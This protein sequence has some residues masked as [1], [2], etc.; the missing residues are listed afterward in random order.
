MKKRIA[1]LSFLIPAGMMA[2]SLL[3]LWGC[4]TLNFG[5]LT[6]PMEGFIPIFFGAFFFLGSLALMIASILRP[7]EKAPSLAKGEARKVMVLVGFLLAF[8][9]I[10]PIFGFSLSTLGLVFASSQVMDNRIRTSFLL[11]GGV[12]AVCYLIFILWLKIPLPS[13]SL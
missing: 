11:A 2:V 5:S 6:L 1:S 7:E 3:Y 10:L 9:L 8:V 4:R 13:W 12:V